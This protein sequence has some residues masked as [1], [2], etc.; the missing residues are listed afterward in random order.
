MKRPKYLD[1]PIFE[2]IAKLV[3]E[4]YNIC[5]AG[6][7]LHMVLDDGNFETC[8]IE[9]S[10]EHIQDDVGRDVTEREKQI[11][12]ELCNL[13][14]KLTYAQRFWIWTKVREIKGE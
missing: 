13:M 3:I 8:H 10:L 4:L 6:G 14:L 12:I 11:C 7:L 9:W 5:C 1:K 2:K